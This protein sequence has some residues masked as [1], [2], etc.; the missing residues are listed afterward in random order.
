MRFYWVSKFLYKVFLILILVLCCTDLPRDNIL[1][2]KNPNSYKAST[3]L[4]EAF[5]NTN[6]PFSYNEWALE[7]LDSIKSIYNQ[8]VLI[9][10]YHRNTSLFTD[11][12]S[13]PVFEDLYTKYVEN[14]EVNQK[15]VP[16]IFVNGITHRVQGASRVENV[17]SRLNNILFDLTAEKNYFTIEKV[18]INTTLNQYT[19]KCKIAR[20]G[21]GANDNIRLRAVF[22]NK[23]DNQYLKC[24]AVSFIK[25]LAIGRIVAGD[26]ILVSFDSVPLDT[27][28]AVIMISITSSDDL[29]VYQTIAVEL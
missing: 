3:V 8:R 1:D 21:I 20:L 10:E 25:S 14:S 26:I 13:N 4:I 19:V 6:N 16:D 24:V 18:G 15:G 2:P 22:L 29:Q 17:I 27:K 28:P 23:I 5:V 7:A 11:S 12:L 9:V